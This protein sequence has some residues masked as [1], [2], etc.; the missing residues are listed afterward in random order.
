MEPW[1]TKIQWRR[2]KMD[3]ILRTTFWN[4][5]FL[6]QISYSHQYSYCKLLLKVQLTT[7]YIG[8]GD[9]LVPLGNKP[10]TKPI[11]TQDHNTAWRYSDTMRSMKSITSRTNGDLQFEWKCVIHSSYALTLANKMMIV[12]QFH[13]SQT[14]THITLRWSWNSFKDRFSTFSI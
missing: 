1:S 9:G 8:V 5:F 11:L 2:N 12:F 6:I 10:L 13:H 7:S 3:G 4:V 14:P